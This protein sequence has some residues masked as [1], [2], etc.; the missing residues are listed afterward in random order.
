MAMIRVPYGAVQG[1]SATIPGHTAGVIRSH[2]HEEMPAA[3][4]PDIP[5]D[6]VCPWRDGVRRRTAD[7]PAGLGS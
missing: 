5:E 3:S 7:L 4:T 2:T 6:P 1:Q